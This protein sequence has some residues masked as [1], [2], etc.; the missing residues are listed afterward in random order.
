MPDYATDRTFTNYVHSHLALP[1]IYKSLNWIPVPINEVSAADLDINHGI[2]YLF[3]KNG[4]LISVQ[5]RFREEQYR[6]YSDFTIRYRRDDSKS[7][8]SIKSE[9]FKMKADY[10][11]YG[12]TNCK[13]DKITNCEGFIKYAVID[14]KQVYHKIESGEIIILNNGKQKCTMANNKMECPIKF[15]RDRSSSFFPID[16]SL[17]INHWGP[18]AVLVQKGFA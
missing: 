18:D 8:N 2:D 15:N 11:V 10:F 9:Y 17:L 13:K 5:E 6:N 12:I 4:N 14:I 3:Q 1:I 7:S 16:I